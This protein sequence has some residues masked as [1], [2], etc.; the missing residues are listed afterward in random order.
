M[1][2]GQILMFGLS[3]LEAVPRKD[4]GTALLSVFS[5]VQCLFVWSVLQNLL[6]APVR[7]PVGR[8]KSGFTR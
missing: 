7:V 5:M 2:S 6:L 8:R 4:F 3:G 1:S